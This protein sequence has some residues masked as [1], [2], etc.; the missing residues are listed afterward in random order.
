MKFIKTAISFV[1]LYTTFSSVQAQNQCESVTAIALE[2]L[3]A[4]LQDNDYNNIIQ[5]LNTIEAT[6]GETEFTLRTKLI[7][8]IINKTNTDQIR[9]KY[10][11]NKFDENLIERWDATYTNR[12]A[13]QQNKKKY[14]YIPLGHRADSLLKVKANALL[15]SLTY[16]H[17]NKEEEALLL[18]FKDDINAYMSIMQPETS[19]VKKMKQRI[20]LE[21]YKEKHTFGIHVGTFLPVGENEYFGK[22]LT[23]GISM[24]SSFS[25]DFVFDVHYKFRVHTKTPAIDFVYKEEIREVEPNSSHVLAIGVGYKLLDKYRFII[26]PKVNAGYGVIWTGLSETVYG[27]DDEGNETET[28][29]PRNVQTMH[30]TFG[31]SIM[32]HISKK[33]YIGI[34]S[35]LHLIPYKWDSR[36]KTTIPSKY[37]SFELFVRF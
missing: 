8:Q 10:L 37:A 27:E 33:T 29:L 3:A 1:I 26:L 5:I 16:N 24:M 22:S 7:Y 13:Y 32:R 18:L 36:L 25:S 21:Q 14:T 12:N 2:K 31:I 20:E 17:L 9:A 35:N 23:G 11:K 19:S 6:C 4:Q 15:N 34:E 28:R 30:S